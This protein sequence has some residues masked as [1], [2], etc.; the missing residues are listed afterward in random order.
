M[1]VKS[2]LLHPPAEV[3]GPRL[4]SGHGLLNVV[5]LRAASVRT[6]TP[7]QSADA[8]GPRLY[9]GAALWVMQYS[10][11]AWCYNSVCVPGPRIRD[12]WP[13]TRPA[14]STARRAPPNRL[15]PASSTPPDHTAQGTPGRS[16]PVRCTM[17]AGQVVVAR[18]SVPP[19]STG[20]NTGRVGPLSC[21]CRYRRRHFVVSVHRL[22][23]RYF[24]HPSAI[25][26]WSSGPVRPSEDRCPSSN[27]RG[28]YCGHLH[29][30]PASDPRPGS[31]A[32]QYR[33]GLSLTSRRSLF[34]D[35]CPAQRRTRGRRMPE[36]SH[37]FP[38]EML[39]APS[40]PR[41]TGEPYTPR[42]LSFPA[43][44]HAPPRVPG[45]ALLRV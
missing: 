8:R 44:I 16:I 28:G 37:S 24:L 1:G 10:S 25:G 39:G 22:P 32:A 30:L 15:S 3:R 5:F 45:L 7:T 23:W 17:R 29:G 27:V 20:A 33:V 2:G 35:S 6:R 12:P 38:G 42:F 31:P 4:T 19:Q 43:P 13:P 14:P 40:L 9:S 41:T 36:R 26:A 34:C 18:H 21:G 11:A